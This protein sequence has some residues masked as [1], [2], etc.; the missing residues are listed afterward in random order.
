MN[1][2]VITL[3]IVVLI[4]DLFTA[5]S[6]CSLGTFVDG[7][8][9]LGSMKLCRTTG[10]VAGRCMKII[11]TTVK[12]SFFPHLSKISGSGVGI[13][14]LIGRRSRVI[15]LVI[16]PLTVLVV[17]ATPLVVQLLLSRRFAP[18]VSMVHFVKMKLFFGTVTCPVK[19]VSFTGKSGGFFF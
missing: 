1:E 11:F 19:C 6:G 14:A 13:Q 12:T 3:K 18:L 9:S 4:S 10:S 5:V 8:N 2:T 17:V 15:V 16:A 7:F